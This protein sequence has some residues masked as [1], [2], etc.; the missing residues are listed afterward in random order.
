MKIR[1]LK[2]VNGTVDGVKMG[3]FVCGQD[4]DLPY[5]RAQSFIASAMAEIPEPDD[6]IEPL[7]AE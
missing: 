1:M 3:P 7:S 4:Y 6:Y 2:T 5:E